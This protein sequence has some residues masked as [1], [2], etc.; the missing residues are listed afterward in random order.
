M[1]EEKKVGLIKE[2]ISF[3]TLIISVLFFII[4][5][6]YFIAEPF[7][8]DGA[9]MSPN[10]ETGHYIIINKLYGNLSDVQRGDVLTFVPPSE[11]SSD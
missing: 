5:F 4:P 11:R 6:K 2:I 7:I 8:V 10:F 9:S 1:K 3:I